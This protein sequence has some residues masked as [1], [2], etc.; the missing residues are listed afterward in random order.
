MDRS[1]LSYKLATIAAFAAIYFIWGT[2]YLA[3]VIGLE[4]F[5]P[6]LMAAVRFIVAGL[7]L[8]G[9]CVFK[10]EKF[11]TA[12]ALVKN[13]VLA[14]VVLAGGQGLLIW[15]EQYIA[16]GYAA[17][18]VA[19]LPIWFVIMD[20]TNWKTYFSNPYIIAGVVLGFLGILLLFK[21]TISGTSMNE[22]VRL[23][24]IA[25]LAVLLGSV[26][27]VAGTL[28]HRTNPAPGSIYLNLGWQLI[29]GSVICSVISVSAGELTS[30]TFT[31]ISWRAWSA[32]LYLSVAGSIIAFIAYT[33]L[34]TQKPSAV[35]G[36]YAYI[37]PVVA[38]FLGWLLADEVINTNQ[39]VGM[40]IILGSAILVNITRAQVQKTSASNVPME[41]EA[42]NC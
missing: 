3:I 4:G 33:W 25:S 16:S 37:N 20:K 13:A 18:L 1:L 10:G 11:P 30:F 17:V 40:S 35:V 34:L 19:T 32:V 6:F 36:T 8:V 22:N 15:S 7:P 12:S 21:D 26:C 29:I 41:D 28:Y 42:V 9:Y 27:W 39:L 24:L 38:V 2:T 23:E 31:H 5:P 14:L